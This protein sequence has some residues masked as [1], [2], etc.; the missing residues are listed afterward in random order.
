MWLSGLLGRTGRAAVPSM[1]LYMLSVLKLL[2]AAGR[3][4]AGAALH[5]DCASTAQ[6]CRAN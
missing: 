6:S 4:P 1:H 5:V 2:L 3:S